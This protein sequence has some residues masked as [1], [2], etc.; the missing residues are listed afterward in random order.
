M[1]LIGDWELVL[2]RAWSARLMVLAALLSGAEV[3]LP[4]FTEMIAPGIMAALSLIVVSAAFI[5]RFVAQQG[6]GDGTQ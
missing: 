4:F 3:A 2:K 6:V 5:A 1:K